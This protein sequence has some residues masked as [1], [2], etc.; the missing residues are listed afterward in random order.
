MSSACPCQA[1]MLLAL[2]LVGLVPVSVLRRVGLVLVYQAVMVSA[3]RLVGLV[4]VY[5]EDTPAKQ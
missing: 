5:L 4:P 1:V 3:L 2:R